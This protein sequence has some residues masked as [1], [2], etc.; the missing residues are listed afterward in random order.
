MELLRIFSRIRKIELE[1]QK[2]TENEY[3]SIFIFLN[4]SILYFLI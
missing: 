2:L 4:R 1:I 3:P